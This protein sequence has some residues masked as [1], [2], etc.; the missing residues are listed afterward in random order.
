MVWRCVCVE[1]RAA[2]FGHYLSV[3]AL[4]VFFV[5]A[6]YFCKN[7]YQVKTAIN[8]TGVYQRLQLHLLVFVVS[9]V[10]WSQVMTI[11][12]LGIKIC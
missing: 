4:Y 7:I 8:Y 11:T 9:A 10:Y 5:A 12:I 3:E 2:H 1:A 6:F